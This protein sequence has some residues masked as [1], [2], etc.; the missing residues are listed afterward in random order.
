MEI[1]RRPTSADIAALAD[2]S[3]ATV[4]YVLNN[5]TDKRISPETRERVLRI[6]RER[7]F[8][9]NAAAVA[10]KTGRTNIVLFDMPY[11]PLG[12]PTVV[13][14]T[15]VFGKLEDL[16]Y[17]PLLHF[18]RSQDGMKLAEA[19][20]G[21]QPVGLIASGRF[22][23][24]AMTENLGANG[25][26]GMVA[27]NDRPL[28]HVPTF[29]F[30]QERV[31]QTAIDY[32]AAR[33]HRRVLALMPLSGDEARYRVDRTAGA[34][35][36]A[37]RLGVEL[38]VD[39]VDTDEESMSACID[40]VFCGRKKPTAIYA[41]NDEYARAAL[42]ALLDRDFS[43]PGDVAVL[44][45]DDGPLAR[46]GWPRLSSIAVASP[47]RW[48]L[49]ASTVDDVIAGRRVR[50]LGKLAKLNIIERATT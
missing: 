21:L 18:E 19:C 47:E 11:W 9:P 33:G 29:V 22:L 3:R 8:V 32:L 25:V 46:L 41:F 27:L 37:D 5:R 48:E 23:T 44:G 16:G 4:S 42:G 14:I 49:I 28:R 20:R 36:S 34:Q 6:A 39:R 15:S 7:G 12:S 17:T 50:G 26:V 10:L 45:C 2:V 38:I 43:I 31:G 40:R 30:S 13:G 24:K 35:R 1:S